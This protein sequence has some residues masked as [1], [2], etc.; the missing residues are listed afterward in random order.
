MHP[1]PTIFL[2]LKSDELKQDKGPGFWKF[3]NSLLE[4]FR[5]VNKLRE[6]VYEYRENHVYLRH[7]ST[8][9][10]SIR[11]A[12]ISTNT[13]PICRPR[14]GR[15]IDRRQPTRM[16]ADTRPI[17][18]RHS[19]DSWPILYRHSADH[20]HL[21]DRPSI[22][23]YY[24]PVCRPSTVGRYLDR[25]STDISTD[26]NRSVMEE[27]DEVQGPAGEGRDD[28]FYKIDA[29]LFLSKKKKKVK[30]FYANYNCFQLST[31]FTIWQKK[32]T[33][34]SLPANSTG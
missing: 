31:L 32:N 1:K 27:N 9:Y 29:N 26:I 20:V 2:H 34:W 28:G 6:N 7:L 16:S 24:R 12:D 25:Y 23:P 3:N 19:A 5:Y 15:H 33:K 8:E 13:R 4:D 30:F 21:S 10:R 14:F 22:G 17:L 18:H 11:S